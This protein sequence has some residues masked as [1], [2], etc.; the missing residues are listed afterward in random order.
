MPPGTVGTN[1]KR[2]LER[3]RNALS[4]S[5]F[6][7]AS[8]A[9]ISTLEGGPVAAAPSVL[10]HAIRDI[11]ATGKTFAG[12]HAVVGTLKGLSAGG[13]ALLWKL[14]LGFAFMGAVAVG[15]M[16]VP[17]LQKEPA[18]SGPPESE[19][20]GKP[21]PKP[22]PHP[23]SSITG[24]ILD[25]RTK[26]PIL[27]VSV[28]ILKVQPNADRIMLLPGAKSIEGGPM[29]DTDKDGC[30]V[31]RFM[32]ASRERLGLSVRVVSDKYMSATKH[33]GAYR[34]EAASAPTIALRAFATVRVKVVDPDDKPVAGARIRGYGGQELVTDEQGIFTDAKVPTHRFSWDVTARGFELKR[35]TYW[36]GD[37][38][39][40]EPVI[41]LKPCD[42]ITGVVL[43]PSGK[44]ASD[45]VVYGSGIYP[46]VGCLPNWCVPIDDKGRFKMDVLPPKG[47]MY[48]FP[49]RDRTVV[50]KP[51]VLKP[52]RGKLQL[53]LFATGCVRV[54][55][56]DDLG[57]PVEGAAVRSSRQ[58]DRF[59]SGTRHAITDKE[60]RATLEQV[61][62]GHTKVD[63]ARATVPGSRV[64]WPLPHREVA[65]RAGVTH[66]CALVV[67]TVRHESPR[68]IGCLVDRNGNPVLHARVAACLKRDKAGSGLFRGGAWTRVDGGFEIALAPAPLARNGKPRWEAPI[69]N[70]TD[71]VR[72]VAM[73][74]GYGR[75]F[76]DVT[77]P[78]PSDA[79]RIDLKR[80]AA[81][82]AED[83][84]FT[85]KAVRPGS[86]AL[87]AY[88]DGCTDKGGK[89][90]SFR[91][92][93]AGTVERGQLRVAIRHDGALR[94]K[95]G[96]DLGHKSDIRLSP[97]PAPKE[98]ILVTFPEGRTIELNVVD[99]ENRPVG[100]VGF[101]ARPADRQWKF[102]G[103]VRSNAE[104]IIRFEISRRAEADYLLFRNLH[105]QPYR[106][107]LSAGQ[108]PFEQ[109]VH[110]N[111]AKAHLAG[112]VTDAAG[113]PLS[114]ARVHLHVHV[115]RSITTSFEMD[116]GKDGRFN[117]PV[118]SG[119]E[120][121]LRAYAETAKGNLE[122]NS[123][124]EEVGVGQR[125]ERNLVLREKGRPRRAPGRPKAPPMARPQEDF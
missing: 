100:N 115:D 125:L 55:V 8:A 118:P 9:L 124:R 30:Y 113:M 70:A 61:P 18:M 38:A 86:L 15:F 95:V 2:G 37:P 6:S 104:G 42:A 90:V 107:R 59:N 87:S 7:C 79:K 121:Q 23:V 56:R 75:N 101:F 72:L 84:V 89:P 13:V 34:G 96:D 49:V 120:V 5:G 25:A 22:L 28:T 51:H 35:F 81:P 112:R 117:T 32:T 10:A 93:D 73:L 12:A 58:G 102:P 63:V 48:V 53:R 27:G 85:L 24:R 4:Q 99:G 76:V 68:L 29:A 14:L 40:G 122:A 57:K 52:E 108:G 19:G 67:S 80:V 91:R 111:R 16:G 54:Q 20:S 69:P 11:V 33:L 88:V 45:V 3:L 44:S 64:K 60:G 1:I 31:L 92:L 114:Q 119:I 98:P 71:H 123:R 77:R 106:G 47:P 116:L 103:A 94:L 105:Y 109:T 62:A 78:W 41:R 26:R 21:K 43:D 36:I 17:D 83:R 66:R 39:E 46:S 110:L 82:L 74:H 97:G 65:V 50:G